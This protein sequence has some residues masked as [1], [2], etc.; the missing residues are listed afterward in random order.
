MVSDRR[1]GLFV[2]NIVIILPGY[3]FITLATGHLED[4]YTLAELYNFEYVRSLTF[5]EEID[6]LV[7]KLLSSEH[8]VLVKGYKT[9]NIYMVNIADMRNPYVQHQFSNTF[10][11]NVTR[12]LQNSETTTLNQ[13]WIIS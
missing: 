12:N 1:H 4:K 3:T 13:R 11:A 8:L 5:D 6:H 9:D 7:A 2:F 10:D